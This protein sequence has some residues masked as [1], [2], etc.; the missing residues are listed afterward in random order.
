MAPTN[1]SPTPETGIP[2][3]EPVTQSLF[4][5][6]CSTNPEVKDSV[7]IVGG[8]GV[9]PDTAASKF[10]NNPKHSSVDCVVATTVG[11]GEIV[12]ITLS[13]TDVHPPGGSHGTN[14]NSYVPGPAVGVNVGFKPVASEKVPVPDII[15]QT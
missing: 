2:I 6:A 9:P 14:S 4:G 11:A 7:I 8:V 3:V 5:I 15:F 1:G 10:V 12:T 13:F